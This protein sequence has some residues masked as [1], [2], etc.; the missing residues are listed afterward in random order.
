VVRVYVNP[1]NFGYFLIFTGFRLTNVPIYIIMGEVKH[2]RKMKME[3]PTNKINN[4][5]DN[6]ADTLIGDKSQP[7][8]RIKTVLDAMEVIKAQALEIHELQAV[9]VRIRTA[10]RESLKGA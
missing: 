9:I 7:A 6:L 10:W 8:S 4:E 5:L 3:I 1:K 2:E